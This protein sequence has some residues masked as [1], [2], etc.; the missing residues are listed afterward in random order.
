MIRSRLTSIWTLIWLFLIFC[1]FSVI[2]M[3]KFSDAVNLKT[4]KKNI[5]KCLQTCCYFND[6]Q[7][8]E[9]KTVPWFLFYVIIFN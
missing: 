8:N 9:S 4:Y 1:D 6:I 7:I 3:I 2:I 5:Y